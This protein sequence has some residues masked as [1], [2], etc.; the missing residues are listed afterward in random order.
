MIVEEERFRLELQQIIPK[1]PDADDFVEGAKWALAR[2][3]EIGRRIGTSI[4]WFL[5]MAKRPN[6]LP[7]ILYYTFDEETVNLISIVETIYPPQD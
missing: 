3:P 6:L 7:I 5:A 2:S 4:V 1:A